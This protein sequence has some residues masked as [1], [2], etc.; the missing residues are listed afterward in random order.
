V[1]PRIALVSNYPADHRTFHGGVETATAA[2]LE[3]LRAFQG[4]FDM[5][6]IALSRSLAADRR[7]E[8]DGFWFHFL[9]LPNAAWLP[10]RFPIR[11]V[12]VY[13]EIRSIEPSLI[14]CHANLVPA[15]GLTLTRYPR[16]LTLHGIATREARLRAEARWTSAAWRVLERHVVREFDAIIC[17]SRY[18][19]TFVGARQTT[20]TIPNAVESQFFQAPGGGQNA[21]CPYVLFV[22]QITPLKRPLDLVLAHDVLRREFPN[23]RTLLCGPIADRAYARQLRQLIRER[24]LDGVR[25]LGPVSRPLLLNL[26]RGATGLVLPSAQENAPMA[27]AEAMA[28]GVP[29]VATRVGGV[30]EMVVEGETGLLYSSG[31]VPAL[32]EALRLL[33]VDPTRRAALGRQARSVARAR[34]APERVAEATVRVYHHLLQQG[35]GVAAAA[36]RELSSEVAL[37]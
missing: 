13:R 21:S 8:R 4:Q 6:V 14:H 24:R 18:A 36:H 22:G 23:L 12:K 16:V 9:S 35:A 25:Y 7:E 5:H 31:D 1:R 27:I 3:G 10:A 30:D 17:I 11:I 2:L 34:Y 28:V 20:F 33:L 29:I 19:S 32:I 15:L 26:L 37:P